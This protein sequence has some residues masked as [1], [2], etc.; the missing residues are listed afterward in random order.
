MLFALGSKYKAFLLWRTAAQRSSSCNLI[1]GRRV[2]LRHRARP[3]QIRNNW[4][5]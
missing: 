2:D 5:S 1:D 4:L 3:N